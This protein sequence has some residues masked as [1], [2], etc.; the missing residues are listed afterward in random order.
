[1]VLGF[2]VVLVVCQIP[3]CLVFVTP[4]FS[5]RSPAP[6]EAGNLHIVNENLS[7]RRKVCPSISS[8]FRVNT[9]KKVA[10]QKQFCNRPDTCQKDFLKREGERSDLRTS[11]TRT[12]VTASSHI[13]HIF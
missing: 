13:S 8:L 6:A 3:Y 2:S 4:V 11:P 7:K 10:S 9:A 1:M 5:L 12:S